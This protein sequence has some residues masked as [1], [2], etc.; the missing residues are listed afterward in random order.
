MVQQNPE[1]GIIITARDRATGQFRRVSRAA[2]ESGGAFDALRKAATAAGVAMGVFGRRIAQL[3]PGLGAFSVGLF[4]VIK[5]FVLLNKLLSLFGIAAL[6][7][8]IVLPRLISKESLLRMIKFEEAMFEVRF[9]MAL[10]GASVQDIA[11]RMDTLNRVFT[12]ANVTGFAGNVAAQEELLRLSPNLIFSIGIMAQ[13]IS[14][15]SG[16]AI[17]AAEAFVILAGKTAEEARAIEASLPAHAEIGENLGRIASAQ[18]RISGIIDPILAFFKDLSLLPKAI[19]VESFASFVEFIVAIPATAIEQF[20][21]FVDGMKLFRESLEG[22]I[23]LDFGSFA[24]NFIDAL[25]ALGG[26]DLVDFWKKILV[27][28]PVRL[29]KEM[30]DAWTGLFKR[31]GE[32]IVILWDAFSETLFGE[33]SIFRKAFSTAIDTMIGLLGR[34]LDFIRGSGTTPEERLGLTAEELR[35]RLEEDR[36]AAIAQQAQEIFSSAQE[37][38]AAAGI[39]QMAPARMTSFALIEE[40]ARARRFQFGGIV[41]GPLGAPMPILAHGGEAILP[42]GQAGTMIIQLVLREEIIGEVAVD[43][44]HRTARFKAGMGLQSI[45]GPR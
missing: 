5:R 1:I 21:K 9:Q 16:G 2:K 29:F 45:G 8:S 12:R 41:P 6:A 40:A 7:A 19:V 39:T 24:T 35:I 14:D 15:L 42:R 43:A 23:E 37:A 22:L 38:F 30:T 25:I 27:D 18:E 34:F 4:T 36:L 31:F 13:K 44:I 3:V 33:G 32:G 28:E 20:G 26:Q 10:L 11:V 17:T